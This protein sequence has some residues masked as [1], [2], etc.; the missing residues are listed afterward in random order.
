[1]LVRRQG[2]RAT[3]HRLRRQALTP[4]D[5]RPGRTS[6]ARCAAFCVPERIPSF[7]ASDHGVEDD[8]ELSHAGDE[9]DLCRLSLGPEALV[10]GLENRV[11]ARGR[12]DDGHEEQV[13]QLAP[14]AL[15]EAS[16][17]M[18]ATVVIVGRDTDQGGSGLVADQ[19]EF[20]QEGDQAGGAGLSQAGHAFDDGAHARRTAAVRDPGRNHSLEARPPGRPG[21]C[22]SRDGALRTS[23]GWSCSHQVGD[24]R[25]R[26]LHQAVAARSPD[27]PAPRVAHRVG[28][29]TASGKVSANQAIIAASIGSFLARA[30]G[31]P[32]EVAHPLGIDDAHLDAS[33]S[34][35][36]LAQP[37]LVPAAGLHHRRADPV[38]PRASAADCVDP[39]RVSAN[40]APT[41]T[42]RMR[43]VDLLLGNIDTDNRPLLCHP[44][45]PSLLVRAPGP[46]NCSGLRKTPDLSLAPP[47]ASA[48]GVNGLRSS[49]GR[50][51]QQPPVRTFSQIS[52]TQGVMSP[53]ETA[54]HDPSVAVRR[55]H[56]PALRVGRKVR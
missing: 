36:S 20:G 34:R 15:D 48:L 41:D 47:Q 49:D 54:A 13:A 10:A 50:L 53:L 31:R 6:V 51:R 3:R 9:G 28:R 1:M 24:L 45:I 56:L 12:P 29:P 46:C 33:A 19:T 2:W 21:S 26:R 23:A 7:A 11:A 8:D 27:G 39:L 44:P 30:A 43:R 16:S 14:A 25:R 5:P 42:D 17:P 55:A 37:P 32:C 38:S 22:R 35:R 40:E 4:A 52:K 18:L